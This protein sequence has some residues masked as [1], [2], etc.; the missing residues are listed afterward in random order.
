MFSCSSFWPF[1]GETGLPHIQQKRVEPEDA[2]PGD[3][4]GVS[5]RAVVNQV[6]QETEARMGTTEGCVL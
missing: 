2:A 4:I 1:S 6:A 5:L 3:C